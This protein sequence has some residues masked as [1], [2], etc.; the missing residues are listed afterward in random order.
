MCTLCTL[1][2]APVK[3]VQPVCGLQEG[4]GG[5]ARLLH[6]QQHLQLWAAAPHK[7]CGLAQ[8]LRAGDAGA[9]ASHERLEAAEG[10]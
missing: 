8:H 10:T 1:D 9:A 3:G 7:V 4:K 2:A 6:A 5:V